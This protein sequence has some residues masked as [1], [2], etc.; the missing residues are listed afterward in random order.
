MNSLKKEEILSILEIEIERVKDESRAPGSLIATTKELSQ[1]YLERL[2][3][4][5]EEIK[6]DASLDKTT[7]NPV[8][9]V[10]VEYDDRSQ[11]DFVL[12]ENAVSFAKLLFIST[13]SALG[14]AIIGKKLGEKFFYE[15]EEKGEKR[16][17]SGKV[18]SIS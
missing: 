12:A 5:K 18:I 3:S 2:D 13:R 1:K 6:N 17:F 10:L 15:I 9:Q 4:L 16:N 7:I 14:K 8:C 11:L